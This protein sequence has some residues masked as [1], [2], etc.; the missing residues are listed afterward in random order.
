VKLFKNGEL[1]VEGGGAAVL[2][3]PCNAL[4]ALHTL[5]ERLPSHGPLEPGELITTGSLT[6]SMAVAPGET[7]STRILGLP[8]PGLT[9]TF[10]A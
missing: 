1:V 9:L 2:G 10:T 6:T 7:W 3:T 8:L 5:L 4:K